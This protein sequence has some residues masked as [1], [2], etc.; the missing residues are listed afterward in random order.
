MEFIKLSGTFSA[1]DLREIAFLMDNPK[2]LRDEFKTIEEYAE[3]LG[4]K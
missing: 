1:E 2:P 3:R 4:E